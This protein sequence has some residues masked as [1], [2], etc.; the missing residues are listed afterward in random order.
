MKILRRTEFG[1]PILQKKAKKVLMKTIGTTSFQTLVKQMIYTMRRAGGVGLAAP[2]IG[3]GIQLAVMET[4]PTK[5][6]PNL[7]RSDVIVTVNPRITYRSKEMQP[8]WEGCL[9]CEGI[10]G[11]VPRAKT[12]SVEYYDECGEKVIAAA[13]GLWAAIFQHEIDHL[14]G[15]TFLDRMRDMKTLMTLKEFRRRI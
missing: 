1:N 9:S 2:Q 14:N 3:K 10:R 8:S 4:R 11:K 12:I 5:T 6:R 15:I 13:G 7:K